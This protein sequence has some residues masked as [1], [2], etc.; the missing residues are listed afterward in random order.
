LVGCNYDEAMQLTRQGLAA[1]AQVDGVELHPWNCEPRQPEVPSRLVFD[2]DPGPDAPFSTVVEAAR[3]MRDDL[4]DLW[5]DRRQWPARRHALAI[6]KRNTPSWPKAKGFAHDVCFRMARDSPS[7]YLV[8]MTKS[9]R[10]GRIFLDYLRNDRMATAVAPL[11]PRAR[12]G[13]TVSMP[14]TWTQVKP[15]LIPS[16]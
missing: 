11:P 10:N 3:E 5:L 14:L 16:A 8:K 1:V 9:L 15:I 4:N 13:A 7:L 6:A 2:L 12:S